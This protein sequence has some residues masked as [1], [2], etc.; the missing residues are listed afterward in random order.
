MHT[1]STSQLLIKLQMQLLIVWTLI[2]QGTAAA[3]ARRGSPTAMEVTPDCLHA[4]LGL[5]R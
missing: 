5:D 4:T 1:S 2:V 3:R